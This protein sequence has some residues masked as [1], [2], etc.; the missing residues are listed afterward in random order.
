MSVPV[1]FFWRNGHWTNGVGPVLPG[2]SGWKSPLCLSKI[3]LQSPPFFFQKIPTFRKIIPIFLKKYFRNIEF[4]SKCQ[5]LILK[6]NP[7]SKQSYPYWTLK[8]PT[9]GI[10][11]PTWQHWRCCAADHCKECDSICS[12][13]ICTRQKIWP[14]RSKK[15]EFRSGFTFNLNALKSHIL[16]KDLSKAL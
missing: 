15:I 6:F 10:N 3:P 8:I 12:Y 1:R 11:S 16:G 7:H 14:T 2:T 9:L 13:P 5:K 4:L